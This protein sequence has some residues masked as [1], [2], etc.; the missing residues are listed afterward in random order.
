MESKETKRLTRC[1]IDYIDIL[2][3][4]LDF[5]RED[6]ATAA[7]NM[8]QTIEELKAENKRQS[9]E[10]VELIASA[11]QLTRQVESLLE[12]LEQAG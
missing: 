3:Q 8:H 11:D 12:T 2:A 5:E 7:Y 1:L 10:I 9:R 4:A 6:A